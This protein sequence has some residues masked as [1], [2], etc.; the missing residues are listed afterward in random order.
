MAAEVQSYVEKKGESERPM[1][2]HALVD[3]N[4]DGRDDAIVLLSGRS[5]C[6]SGGCNMLVLRGT[7][8]GFTVISASTITSEPVVRA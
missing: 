6:G 8:E 5:W 7:E 4:G 3:L 1:F 2:R